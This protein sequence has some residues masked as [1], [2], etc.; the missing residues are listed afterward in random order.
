VDDWIVITP[1][2]LESKRAA[3]RRIGLHR[4]SVAEFLI[5]LVVVFIVRETT[6]GRAEPLMSATTIWKHK[7]PTTNSHMKQKV[8]LTL[9]AGALTLTS[10]VDAEEGGSGH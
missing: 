10:T 1:Q 2:P 8:L 9:L 5:A 4:Y 6:V 3:P 7:K